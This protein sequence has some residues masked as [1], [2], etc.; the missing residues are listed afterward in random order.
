MQKCQLIAEEM[1]A[2]VW[3]AAARLEGQP[4]QIS[5]VRTTISTTY[6]IPVVSRRRGSVEVLAV[7]V[8]SLSTRRDGTDASKA[9]P[10]SEKLGEVVSSAHAHHGLELTHVDYRSTPTNHDYDNKKT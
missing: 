5:Q 2:S 3:C 1:T 8:L 6:E 4:P 7:D 9:S 10:S